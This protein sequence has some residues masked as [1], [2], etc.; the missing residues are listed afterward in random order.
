[1]IDYVTLMPVNMAAGSVG[2][3]SR[4]INLGMDRFPRILGT[5]VSFE[6]GL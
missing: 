5:S 3:D 6:I 2:S 1:M 4:R